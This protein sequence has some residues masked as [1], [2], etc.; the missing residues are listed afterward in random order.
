MGID[1]LKQ[2]LV[3]GGY[4]SMPTPLFVATKGGVG[5]AAVPDAVYE[6]LAAV[7]RRTEDID[8]GTLSGHTFFQVVNALPEARK[9]VDIPM[10]LG[11]SAASMCGSALCLQRRHALARSLS[12]TIYART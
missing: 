5:G 8:F 9:L 2:Q 11:W 1:F 6:F 7:A 12:S 3:A 10:L 4:F